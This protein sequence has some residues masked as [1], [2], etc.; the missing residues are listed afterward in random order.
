MTYVS[1]RIKSTIELG[2]TVQNKE[3][4]VFDN[5]NGTRDKYVFVTSKFLLKNYSNKIEK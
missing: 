2:K 3:C 1:F 5:R 4:L